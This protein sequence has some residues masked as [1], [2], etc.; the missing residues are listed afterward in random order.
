M[1]NNGV[2]LAGGKS[3]RMGED[4]A[5]LPFGKYSSLSRYQYEKMKNLFKNVY[6]SAKNNKFDFP[7][8]IILDKNENFS[9]LIA[10][11]SILEELKQDFFLISVDM[12]LVPKDDIK[13]LIKLYCSS[14]EFEIYTVKTSK[15]LE[16]TA[17]IYTQKVLPII[18]KMLSNNQHKL[19]NL[20]KNSKTAYLNTKNSGLY[21]NINNKIEYEKALKFYKNL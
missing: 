15:G 21:I 18:N 1:L 9:P 2:I 7:A 19:Q 20:L 11:K 12:P 17:A 14:K 16:P 8:K 4:K 3:S 10:I 6:I 5:L 13:N